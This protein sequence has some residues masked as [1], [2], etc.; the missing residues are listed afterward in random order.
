MIITQWLCQFPNWLR[1]GFYS[2]LRG[3]LIERKR[4]CHFIFHQWL[5]PHSSTVTS[6]ASKQ[7]CHIQ[8][9]G[10]RPNSE[11]LRKRTVPFSSQRPKKN[12]GWEKQWQSSRNSSST[13][14]S[15]RKKTAAKA[16]MI[17]SEGRECSK[18]KQEDKPSWVANIAAQTTLIN[19]IN[20]FNFF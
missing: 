6:S 5:T 10:M 14:A 15:Q 7:G 13:G 12:N 16:I 17:S 3:T 11:Q 8:M 9:R 20:T 1:G 18:D 4:F 2:I 19:W